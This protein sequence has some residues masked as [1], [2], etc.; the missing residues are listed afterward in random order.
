[1][2]KLKGGD[3]TPR[4]AKKSELYDL[5]VAILENAKEWSSLEAAKEDILS[6][7]ETLEPSTAMI[8]IK[9]TVIQMETLPELIKYCYNLRLKVDGLGL[10]RILRGK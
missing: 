1:M 9:A 8:R 2:I 5:A 6:C 3:T 10:H 7:I 4:Q